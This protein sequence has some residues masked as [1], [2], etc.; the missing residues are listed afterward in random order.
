MRNTRCN[1]GPA[2]N[3]SAR[4]AARPS[5]G[6][7]LKP[8]VPDE[9]R[10]VRRCGELEWFSRPLLQ[11]DWEAGERVKRLTTVVLRG[12]GCDAHSA[13]CTA[14]H[15]IKDLRGAHTKAKGAKKCWSRLGTCPS[16]A[17]TR[18]AGLTAGLVDLPHLRPLLIPGR[19]LWTARPASSIRPRS[20]GL[21]SDAG[22]NPDP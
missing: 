16:P 4:N 2:I 21:H 22:R 20:L 11:A 3:S 10:G 13:R 6:V 15:C 1:K 19:Q 17:P 8:F 5:Y 7:M 14:H 12:R 9:P 18:T